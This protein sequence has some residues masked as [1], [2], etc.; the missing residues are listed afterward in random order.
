MLIDSGLS[1]KFWAEAANTA[2]FLINKVP[3]RKESRSPD[4]IWSGGSPNLKFL[5]IFGSPALVHI[6]KEKRRKLDPKS[7]EC[8]MVGYS[9]ESKA[10]RLFNPQTENVIISR[11]VVFLEKKVSRTAHLK[12]C[13]TQICLHMKVSIQRI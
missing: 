2:C 5:R 1:K 13:F 6:P 4:E 8:I 3:C 7:V 10:Y 12:A 9:S 11:D